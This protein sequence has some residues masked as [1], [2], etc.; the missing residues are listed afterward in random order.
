MP[1]ERLPRANCLGCGAVVRGPRD[2]YCSIRCQKE[3]Q[4]TEFIAR[5]KAGEVRGGRGADLAVSQHIRRYL[6]EQRGERCWECGWS[7]RNPVTG[8]VPVTVD[9]IDGDGKNHTEANLRLLCPNCHSLTPTYQNLNRGK[10][11]PWRREHYK[12]AVVAQW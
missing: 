2:R 8:R 5:W 10:G 7:E 11:R 4:Y 1:R 6:I 9:H 12:P 3:R